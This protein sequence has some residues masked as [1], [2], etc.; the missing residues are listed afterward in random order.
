MMNTWKALCVASLALG[1]APVIAQ[2][3][4][5]PT[6]HPDDMRK[7]P[8]RSAIN[9]QDRTFMKEAAYINRAEVMLGQLARQKGG[10]WAREYGA[11]MEREHTAAFEEQK[12]T[13]RRLGISLPAGIDRMHQ[14]VYDRLSRLSGSAFDN[15]YRTAMI[16]GHAAAAAKFAMEIRRGNNSMVRNYAV[17]MLPGVKLHQTLAQR[18]RTLKTQ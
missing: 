2:V 3:R 15:A 12:Q 8:P 17:T 6:G 11:D 18:R 14:N 9:R 10:S 13:A 16:N 5:S 4:V 1:I 7:I